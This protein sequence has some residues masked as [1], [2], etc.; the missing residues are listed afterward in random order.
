MKH[1][2]LLSI[3]IIA[4]VIISLNAE[5]PFKIYPE[6]FPA[7]IKN[8]DWHASQAKK[9]STPRFLSSVSDPDTANQV[10]RLG[11][12]AEE[13][14]G[15]L[16]HPDGNGSITLTHAQHFYSQ[17]NPANLNETFAL[18]SAGRNHN[19]AALWRLKDKKLVAWVP[20]PRAEN[21]IAQRQL[22]WD[23]NNKNV[24][25]Y[26][27]SNKLF[28]VELNLNNYSANSRIWD[29]FPDYESITFGLGSGDFSDDGSKIVL[30][31][32]LKI[33]NAAN[34]YVILS[35]LVN[36]KKISSKMTIKEKEGVILDW[37][38]VDPTGEFIVFN[39]PSRGNSTWVL[40]FNLEGKPRLLYKH[41]KHSDFV[42]DKNGDSWIAFGNW[43]GVFVSKL[44]DSNL[45]RIWPE[46]NTVD[47][48]KYDGSNGLLLTGESASGHISRVSSI[49]GLVLVSR[50]EDGGLYYINIDKPGEIIYVGNTR[51]GKR[52][53][54]SPLTK[55]DWGVDSNGEVVSSDGGKDYYREPRA[56]AS[57]SGKYIFFVSDYHV[58]GTNYL[59]NP[60]PKAYLNM[61]ELNH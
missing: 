38:G 28:R 29:I 26:T 60:V 47:I 1:L 61:I 12:S 59:S 30:V 34:D 50:N 8:V 51:H 6:Y 32:K 13:M 17:T 56:S 23:K 37:A 18:G 19:Y 5:M 44:S 4:S 16:E 46:L 3:L 55:A 53:K 22:L 31:G 49:A 43:Q 2:R 33:N 14:G 48:E 15:I 41:T 27:D 42:V 39:E 7:P 54:N 20:S 57:S 25:W 36:Q 35:Y 40:P 9:I 45:K 10:W 11:G 21:G 58:Y 24:Y 52:P